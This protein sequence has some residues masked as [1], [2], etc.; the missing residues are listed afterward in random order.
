MPLTYDDTPGSW[1]IYSKDWP[2]ITFDSEEQTLRAYIAC[3]KANIVPY[4][5]YVMLDKCLRVETEQLKSKL[6]NYLEEI[7]H[8]SYES[9]KEYY[10]QIKKW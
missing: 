1:G 9:L 6:L 4:G 10:K 3:T 2:S 8:K 7:P 5:S